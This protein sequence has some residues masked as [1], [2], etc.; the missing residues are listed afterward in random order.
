IFVFIFVAFS[1][2]NPANWTPFMPFG[3][4]GVM[5]GAAIVFFAY[6]G[7]DAVS[8]ASEES[9]NPQRDMPIGIIA[10]LAICTVLYIVVAAILTGVVPYAE[11]NNPAPVA[12][13]LNT[14]G[15]RWGSA[16]VS[17]GAITGITSVLL[18]LLMGQ[19]RIF[20]AM[21][22][23]GLLWSWISKVH[24]KY[25]TPYRSQVLTGLVVALVAGFIDIGTAAELTNIGT[26]FAFALV[27]AGVM[28][29]RKTEPDLHR[30]FK[31]PASPWVPML[32]IGFCVW[33]MMAL[34]VLTW[35]RFGVWL[36]LGFLIYFSYSRRHS[37]LASK[38]K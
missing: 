37:R 23:D 4:G 6:I 7:F 18:V 16:L 24:P 17:V 35:I 29:L 21:S 14:L 27:C 28:I 22:R 33:L 5:T 19:P 34:P 2:V 10:S 38:T 36:L 13:V 1:K 30:H 32:G 26:L 15:Y 11:L 20:F 9:K 12:T 3:F 8:C 25:K 31:C